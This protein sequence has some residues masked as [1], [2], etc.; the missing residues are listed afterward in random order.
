MRSLGG[1][2]GIGGPA[3]EEPCHADPLRGPVTDG[4][5]VEIAG[6]GIA[7][8]AAAAALA[9]R[10]WRVRVHERAPELRAAG[11]GG[12]YLYENGL[13][14]LDALGAL[15]DA[16]RGASRA[17]TREVRGPD[18]ALI[19]RHDWGAA[20]R[21]HSVTRDRLVGALARAATR[22]GAEVVAG[23]RAVSAGADGTLRLADGEA[24]ADLVIAADGAS[25][26]L[27]D[28]VGLRARR[29]AMPDGAIR[30]LIPKTEAE[31]AGGDTGTTVET[32]SGSRRILLTPCSE[33]DLYLALTMLHRDEAARA[34]PID[35]A[36]WAHAFPALADVV[37]RIG[38]AGRYDRFERLDLPRWSAGRVA[39]LGDAAHAMP[40]NI[41]QGG[42][43]SMMNAL[44]LAEHATRASDLPAALAAWER[45]ERPLTEHTQRISTFLGRPATWPRPLQRGFFA[46]AGRSRRLAELRSRTA[47]HVPTGTPGAPALAP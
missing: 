15:E 8:L 18:G 24:R 43:C 34:T 32:W 19:S 22:A 27:R 33:A 12:I 44:S 11:A 4:R 2:A 40:P 39:V 9:Q 13:R 45:R 23:S 5:R 29:R 20:G 28:A 46:L 37:R 25:S 21:V 26:A 14:V 31:R 16:T 35:A 3:R 17:T 1:R 42:G 30:L 7:G 47:R 36:L 38:G 41:G 10:G 6:A